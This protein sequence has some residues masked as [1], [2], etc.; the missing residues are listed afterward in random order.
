MRII[1][2]GKLPGEKLYVTS[3]RSCKTVFEFTRKE[4]KMVYDQRDGDFLQIQCPLDGCNQKVF[5]DPK[6]YKT[7]DV[8]PY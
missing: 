1:K 5:V 7:S 2:E 6:N 3:C 8:D 4:S